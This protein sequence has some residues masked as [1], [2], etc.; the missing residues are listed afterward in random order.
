MDPL[1][2]DEAGSSL[3]L[4]DSDEGEPVQKK[5]KRRQTQRIAKKPCA[6][7]M[8]AT[9]SPKRPTRRFPQHPGVDRHT[10]LESVPIY[11]F[12]VSS[13]YE[14]HEQKHTSENQGC[15]EL[16]HHFWEIFSPERIAPHVRALGK[17][18]PRSID[19][20]TGWDLLNETHQHNLIEDLAKCRPKVLMLSP[21]CTIFSTLMASN[22]FRM[23]P[24]SRQAKACAGI[25]LLDFAVELMALQ[26][27][28]R[29]VY[30]FEHP[31]GA[32]SW[33]RLNLV[34]LPGHTVTFDMCMFGL[35]APDGL[36]MKKST[37]FKTNSYEVVD[38]LNG[39]R[40][41]HKHEHT[42]IQGVQRGQR[43][44]ELAAKYPKGLCQKLANIINTL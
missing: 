7:T 13:G 34:R 6:S 31:Q 35:Q 19:L 8:M 37:T 20:L 43:L 2:D 10:F 29:R 40:C 12:G 4:P 33:K 44:S 42:R 24:E 16:D 23:Q 38:A 22:W 32:R 11:S 21:P 9:C 26:N 5:K 17:S 41:L 14:V 25:K 28:K 36:Y 15:V 30:I 39:F 3:D 27:A 18:A 1:P